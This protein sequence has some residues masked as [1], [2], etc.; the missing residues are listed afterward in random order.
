MKKAINSQST[1]ANALDMAARG[2][3]GC[4]KEARYFKG[5]KL[6][7]QVTDGVWLK[8]AVKACYRNVLSS[9]EYDTPPRNHHLNL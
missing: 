3:Q 2:F 4:T 5:A 8:V 6:R 9:L 1:N 7:P